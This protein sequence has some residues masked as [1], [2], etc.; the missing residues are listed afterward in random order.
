MT[1]ALDLTKLAAKAKETDAPVVQT[2]GRERRYAVNPMLGVVQQAKESGKAIVLPPVPGKN[3]NEVIS[4]IR[5][6]AK[7][8]SVGVKFELPKNYAEQETVAVKF[9]TG[10]KRNYTPRQSGS[11][12]ECPVCKSEVSVTSDGNFRVH[13]PRDSRCAGSGVKAA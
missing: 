13:G 3:A 1:A 9:Q 2:R 4:Y 10:E 6:A 8:L 7:E 12:A 5:N 11:K